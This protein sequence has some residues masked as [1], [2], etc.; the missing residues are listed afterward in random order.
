MQGKITGLTN[1][2]ATKETDYQNKLADMEFTSKLES[3]IT[4]TGAKNAK[5]VKALLDIDILKSSKNQDADIKTALEACQ[6]END[7]LFGASEPVVNPVS[8]TL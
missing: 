5:A 6:K 8:G 3:A 7:Y 1:D 2:L 4:A